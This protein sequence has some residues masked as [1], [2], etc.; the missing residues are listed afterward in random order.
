MP[1]I[2]DNAV[3]LKSSK[4][5]SVKP[6]P[7]TYRVTKGQPVGGEPTVVTEDGLTTILFKSGRKKSAE[8]AEQFHETGGMFAPHGGA[9]GRPKELNF[10]FGI[11]VTWT[12][13]STSDLYLGQGSTGVRNNWWLGGPGVET[14]RYTKPGG[15]PMVVSGLSIEED[16]GK[17]YKQIRDSVPEQY[18]SVVDLIGLPLFQSLFGA[19]NVFCFEP[20]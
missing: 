4:I 10:F 14:G 5:A 13:G 7:G 1:T 16:I 19:V 8:V 2:R 9:G 20:E 15:T 3:I 17:S 18:R 11:Q 12:D 6:L